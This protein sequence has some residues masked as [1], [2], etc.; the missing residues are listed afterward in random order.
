MDR[1]NI[2]TAKGR[3]TTSLVRRSD[4]TSSTPSPASSPGSKSGQGSESQPIDNGRSNSAIRGE[5]HQIRTYVNAIQTRVEYLQGLLD[6]SAL[7]D[8]RAMKQALKNTHRDLEKLQERALEP[9]QEAIQCLVPSTYVPTGANA[10]RKPRSRGREADTRPGSGMNDSSVKERS[11]DE[12]V[13][14]SIEVS[15][16]ELDSYAVALKR[17]NA[18]HTP[19]P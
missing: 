5:L 11:N 7:D 16:D 12:R 1:S 8:V 10:S 15:S 9:E 2:D 18:M 3:K 17:R 19:A 14:I 6:P 13:R 4:D